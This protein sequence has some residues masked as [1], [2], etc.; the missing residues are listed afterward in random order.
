MY[1]GLVG[2]RAPRSRPSGCSS[3][4]RRSSRSPR[5]FAPVNRSVLTNPKVEI[6]IGDAR[7]ALL[8]T[9]ERYDVIVSEPS[10]PYRAGIAS[11][12]TRELYRA[13]EER[14][15][16][17]G[18]F[19]QW[20]QSYEIDTETL[21]TIYATLT[22]VFP[23]VSTW[24]TARFDI[25]LVASREP[26]TRSADDLRSRLAKE[27]YAEAINKVWRVDDL[28]GVLAHHLA[29][30]RVARELAAAAGDRL[31][32]DDRTRIEFAFAR[33]LGRKAF[34]SSSALHQFALRRDDARPS[35]FS[36]S[37]DWDKVVDRENRRFGCRAP[38]P[39]FA[40]GPRSIAGFAGTGPP[41][42]AFGAN[43]GG[44]RVVGGSRAAA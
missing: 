18:L 6:E 14:L 31:N 21:R 5:E 15:A 36:G 35:D 27:P 25:V 10:N 17:G 2:C 11:L 44:R 8:T 29:G 28:E 13:A 7:E 19:V 32:T 41:L 39:G 42:V 22:S 3:S 34:W 37:I 20:V 40:Y 26:L 4:R 16:E 43:S 1:R 23:E 9:R 24:E 12:F 33:H 38:Q 30:P